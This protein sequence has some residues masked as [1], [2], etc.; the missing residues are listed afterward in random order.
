MRHSVLCFD[1]STTQTR[2]MP[3]MFRATLL[4]LTEGEAE[5]ENQLIVVFFCAFIANNSITR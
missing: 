3:K 1:Q 4:N 5:S 2:L